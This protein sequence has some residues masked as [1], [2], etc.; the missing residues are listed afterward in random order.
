MVH[1]FGAFLH[2][3]WNF[4]GIF[5]FDLSGSFGPVGSTTG[6]LGPVG[7]TTGSLGPVG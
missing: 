1:F 3:F 5:G 6:S 7:S 2:L 4:G